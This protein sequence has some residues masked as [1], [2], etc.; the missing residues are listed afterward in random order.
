MSD[1]L[2]NFAAQVDV[3][4]IVVSPSVKNALTSLGGQKTITRKV[5]VELDTKKL[6]EVSK[7]A[8]GLFSSLKESVAKVKIKPDIVFDQSKLTSFLTELEQ[9]PVVLRIIKAGIAAIQSK[10]ALLPNATQEVAKLSAI[11][12]SLIE[13][14]REGEKVKKIQIRP[15]VRAFDATI[16]KLRQDI[17]TINKDISSIS[18]TGASAQF[19]RSEL[20]GKLTAKQEQLK[21]TLQEQEGAATRLSPELQKQRLKAIRD[22]SQIA[23]AAMKEQRD[24]DKR[25]AKEKQD[26]EKKLS[27]QLAVEERQRRAINKLIEKATLELERQRNTINLLSSKGVSVAPISASQDQL[28]AAAKQ[29]IVG[30]VDVGKESG[31]NLGK[32]LATAQERSQ[33]ASRALREFNNDVRAVAAGTQSGFAAVA[34]YSDNAFERL[35]GR[36]GLAAERVASYVIGAAGLYTVVSATSAAIAETALLEKEITNLQQIFDSGEGSVEDFTTRINDLRDTGVDLKKQFFDLSIATGTSALSIAKSAKILAAAGFGKGDAGFESTIRAVTLAELGPSF[37]NT[38]EIIDGLIA[39]INQFNLTLQETPY[40]L[41]L[42]NETSKAYAVESQDL[43]EAI[44]RGGGSFA[45]VGGNLED[46]ITL[47]TVTREKTRE[48]APVIGT[49]IKTLS[50]KLFTPKAN[51]L[52]KE[53][54][55]DAEKVVDPFQRIVKLSEFFAKNNL[56]A[57]QK[58]DILSQIVDVRQAGRLAALIDGLSDYEA[59]VNRLREQGGISLIDKAEESILRDAIQRLDDI[60][61]ALDRI[62]SGFT[63]FIEGIYNNQFTRGLLSIPAGLTTALGAVGQNKTAGNFINPLVFSSLLVGLTGIIR[64][65][66]A[67]YRQNSINVQSNTNSLNALTAAIGTFRSGILGG[68]VAAGAGGAAPLVAGAAAG[69]ASSRRRGVFGSG[70]NPLVAIGLATALPGIISTAAPALGASPKTQ[71]FLSG[72]SAGATTGGI[73]GLTLGPK[74]AAAGAVIGGVIGAITT[75]IENA[76]IE[77]QIS[78]LRTQTRLSFGAAN[79]EKS[80]RAGRVV[81]GRVNLGSIAIDEAIKG[82]DEDSKKELAKILVRGVPEGKDVFLEEAKR[83][84]ALLKLKS[85]DFEGITDEDFQELQRASAKINALIRSTFL[86]NLG[87]DT[88]ENRR[89]A[90]TK[91]ADEIAKVDFGGIQFSREEISRALAPLIN[92]TD[93]FEELTFSVKN[94]S[95]ISDEAGK[96][97]SLLSSSLVRSIDAQT[98]A[99]NKFAESIKRSTLDIGSIKNI[100]ANAFSVPRAQTLGSSAS[101]LAAS[102]AISRFGINPIANVSPELKRLSSVINGFISE[103]ATTPDVNLRNNVLSLLN[104]DVLKGIGGNTALQEAESENLA[105]IRGFQSTFSIADQIRGTFSDLANLGPNAK[106]FLDILA[107]GTQ[108][109]PFNVK[110]IASAVESKEINAGERILGI[111]DSRRALIDQ[112]NS[113]IELQNYQLEQQL[114]IAEAILDSS[115]KRREAELEVKKLSIETANSIL[116]LRA[117]VG[118]SGRREVEAAASSNAA[119]ILQARGGPANITGAGQTITL[120]KQAQVDLQKLIQSGAAGFSGVNSPLIAQINAA[121]GRFGISGGVRGGQGSATVAADL[122]TARGLVEESIKS[123]LSRAEDAFKILADKIDIVNNRLQ[124][125]RNTL[126][127]FTGQLFSGGGVDALLNTQK[128]Q[129]T[130]QDAKFLIDQILTTNPNFGSLGISQ[131]EA[132]RTIANQISSGIATFSNQQISDLRSFLQTVGANEFTGTNVSGEELL[133]AIRGSLAETISTLTGVALGPKDIQSNVQ[134]AESLIKQLEDERQ[135]RILAQEE[136]ANTIDGNLSVIGNEV[137]SLTKAIASIPSEIKLAI[138]GVENI[139]V[140]FDLGQV[141]KSLADV[142]NQVFN[143]LIE[144]VREAFRRSGIPVP[145][146]TG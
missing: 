113:L 123:F 116:N 61:P 39:S 46:F 75:A 117:A 131:I 122:A 29:K 102:T 83:N 55:V 67:A 88:A 64:G 57:A 17:E 100:I 6:A 76:S 65:A 22:E 33:N 28:R 114:Q 115:I 137:N 90:A 4:R 43:F 63:A 111:E 138:T 127:S 23:K 62:K 101:S 70:I 19:R 7:S 104:D 25:A 97:I 21:F 92:S 82:A 54:G 60:G 18:G 126:D 119:N 144:R 78:K 27:R 124:E 106:A 49:F 145:E 56:T 9:I 5:K 108:T 143:R 74:G 73:L 26:E 53:I 15:E 35:G 16:S 95:E 45:A 36:V 84:E 91:T 109:L 58:T 86:E 13:I 146:L 134:Q 105:A 103:L 8:E 85:G 141:D 128:I 32:L 38:E 121:L 112:A 130:A 89:R 136:L 41:G 37:G 68:A 118:I 129:S 132:S 66:I 81:D 69:A 142:G 94:L 10:P 52:F 87:V 14:Q 51:T 107:G 24:A 79:L 98:N 71:S 77:D 20:T 96:N 72:I 12:T 120:I 44:K 40:I 140:R 80:I 3:S 133:A 42:V 30:D 99:I 125:Q 50:S 31:E 59:R 2:L 135:K 139:S 48:A 93:S 34:K 47:V 110:D 1:F 11:K